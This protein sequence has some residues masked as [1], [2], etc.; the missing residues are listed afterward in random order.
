VCCCRKIGSVLDRKLV[1][2][3]RTCKERLQ[4]NSIP[5]PANPRAEVLLPLPGPSV[6]EEALRDPR[7]QIAIDFMRANLHRRI[8]LAELAEVANLSPSHLSRL[9]KIQTRLSPGEYL[10][11]L[12]M[13]KA[14]HLVATGLLSVKEIMA[15]VGYK[16]KSHFVRDFQNVLRPGA[17]RIQKERLRPQSDDL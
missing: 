11:R 13:E 10:R 7:I 14:R 4:Y 2:G 12:R 9:F 17:L 6:V 15:T 16:S 5:F 3:A 8:S 1:S